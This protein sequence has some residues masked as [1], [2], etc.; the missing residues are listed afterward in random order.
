MAV[1][2]DSEDGMLLST[3]LANAATGYNWVAK[4]TPIGPM[5][6]QREEDPWTGS[7]QGGAFKL[8]ACDVREGKDGIDSM[9]ARW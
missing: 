2:A 4:A 3:R 8:A 7:N 6:R 9:L 1:R 5:V